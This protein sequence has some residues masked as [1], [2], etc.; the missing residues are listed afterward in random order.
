MTHTGNDE[1]HE[2]NKYIYMKIFFRTEEG[3]NL[4]KIIDALTNYKIKTYKTKTK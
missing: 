2:Q 4:Y 1:S 3:K